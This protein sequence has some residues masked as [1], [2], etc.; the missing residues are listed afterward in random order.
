VTDNNPNEGNTDYVGN[1]A[2]DLYRNVTA[3]FP[4]VRS[5]S[6]EWLDHSGDK[7]MMS[8]YKGLKRSKIGRIKDVFVV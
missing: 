2:I 6:V 1:I 8:I 3:E 4:D 7:L 5:S